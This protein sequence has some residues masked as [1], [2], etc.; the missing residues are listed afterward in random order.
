MIILGS[1][2]NFSYNGFKK[3]STVDAARAYRDFS[4]S[5]S[6]EAYSPRLMAREPIATLI[7]YL[8]AAPFPLEHLFYFWGVHGFFVFFPLPLLL[9]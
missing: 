1:S 6:R 9:Y 8:M 7:K 5:F 3:F 2:E 4:G